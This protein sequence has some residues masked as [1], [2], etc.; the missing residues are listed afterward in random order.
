MHPVVRKAVFAA[1]CISVKWL[2]VGVCVGKPPIEFI[3][4]CFLCFT[5]EITELKNWQREISENL[6]K[7][8]VSQ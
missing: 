2:C 1:L 6:A 8:Q 3:V 7:C 5:V 4:I